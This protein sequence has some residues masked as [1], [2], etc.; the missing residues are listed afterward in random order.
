MEV[1]DV[2]LPL[3]LLGDIEAKIGATQQD[4]TGALSLDFCITVV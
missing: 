2:N 3:A 4:G 1:M